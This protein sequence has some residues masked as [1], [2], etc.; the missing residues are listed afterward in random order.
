MTLKGRLMIVSIPYKKSKRQ[1]SD[2]KK[3][4]DLQNIYQDKKERNIGLKSSLRYSIFMVI[5]NTSKTKS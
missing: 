2:M 5:T 1:N 4:L 3:E